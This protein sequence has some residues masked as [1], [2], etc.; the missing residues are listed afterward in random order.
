MSFNVSTMAD[1]GGVS[2][3]YDD[4]CVSING[5]WVLPLI[6]L[7]ATVAQYEETFENF[8][9]GLDLYVFAEIR[10]GEEETCEFDVTFYVMDGATEITR[11]GYSASLSPNTNCAAFSNFTLPF[12]Q[13]SSSVSMTCAEPTADCLVTAV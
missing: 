7:T 13:F 1:D 6:S 12:N 10:L 8:C 3:T 9:D 11:V 5:D 4:C 2:S